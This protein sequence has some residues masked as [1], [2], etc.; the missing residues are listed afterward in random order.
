M[1]HLLLNILINAQDASDERKSET[2][3]AITLQDSET[4]TGK[5]SPP[6]EMQAE[7]EDYFCISILDNGLGI[8]KLT[9]NR[10]FEPFFTTKAIGKGTGM[11]LA[12]AYGTI[13]NHRGWIQVESEVGE[14][15]EFDIFLP[16]SV[17]VP[18]MF[19]K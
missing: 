12:M 13:S 1:L 11:G 4:F 8:D 9:M 15:T 18:A 19:D 5:W 6:S 16:H 17:Y 3:L 10:I 14:G 2:S 7:K